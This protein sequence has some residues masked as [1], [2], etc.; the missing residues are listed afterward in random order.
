ML[1]TSSIHFFQVIQF[2]VFSKEKKDL[3]FALANERDSIFFN[4]G[5]ENKQSGITQNV[6]L[7]FEVS[8]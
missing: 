3:G 1:N 4:H 7:E 6:R 2:H 5:R 8:G